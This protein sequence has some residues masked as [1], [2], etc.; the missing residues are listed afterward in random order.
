MASLTAVLHGKRQLLCRWNVSL[1]D[2]AP[3]GVYWLQSIRKGVVAL[4][5]CR[6]GQGGFPHGDVADQATKQ[7]FRYPSYRLSEITAIPLQPNS[8]ASDKE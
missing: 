4:P 7:V 1:A 2:A 8:Y 3:P 5:T 6:S